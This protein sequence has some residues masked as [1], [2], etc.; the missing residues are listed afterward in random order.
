[1]L[2]IY[3]SFRSRYSERLKWHKKITGSIPSDPVI[4]LLCSVTHLMC[5]AVLLLRVDE[6]VV[7]SA[8]S[9]R[10]VVLAYADD[11]VELA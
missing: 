7:Y 2:P 10:K 4:L 11:Y 9:L 5:A 1:M 8:D 3:C 6:H